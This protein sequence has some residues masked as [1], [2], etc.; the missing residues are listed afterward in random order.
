LADEEFGS[1][2]DFGGPG[3]HGFGGF[4]AG[5][6]GGEDAGAAAEIEGATEPTGEL[7]K[8]PGV[9]G[10]A[11]A[12]VA[13]GHGGGGEEVGHEGHGSIGGDG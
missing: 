13:F 1:W 3:E 9:D 4:E 10:G 8:D 5:E 11:R 7:A 6:G 12:G 2:S